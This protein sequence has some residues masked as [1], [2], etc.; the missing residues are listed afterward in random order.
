MDAAQALG[1]GPLWV[2]E[3]PGAPREDQRGTD[4]RASD[5]SADRGHSTTLS[6]TPT[7][8]DNAIPC[9]FLAFSAHK[10]HGLTGIGGLWC[11][12]RAFDTMVPTLGG[13]GM[14]ERVTLEGFSAAPGA[15]AFEPGTPAIAAAV[16]MDAALSYLEAL[17]LEQ[18]RRHGESLCAQ[19]VQ[20]LRKLPGVRILGDPDLARS[21]LVS[22]ALDGA[23]PHDVS[24]WLSVRDVMVRAGHHCAM[25]LHTALGVRASLRASFGV[26]CGSADVHRLVEA[27]REIAEGAAAR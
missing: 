19:V 22:F 10:L 16:A 2:E 12:E 3:N 27:V 24:E 18:V 15:A 26:H 5:A 7:D 1:H 17:G 8:C 6:N 9:D 23:H 25:P 20:E 11:S 4:P 21:S 14:I 13:G